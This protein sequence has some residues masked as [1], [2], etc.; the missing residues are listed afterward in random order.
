MYGFRT[1]L[2]THKKAKQLT[3]PNTDKTLFDYEFSV[4]Q[5]CT[6]DTHPSSKA[7]STLALMS[8]IIETTL[9]AHDDPTST[10]N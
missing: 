9:A 10:R 3:I 5:V 1:P 7:T 4:E 8:K 2:S 6:M